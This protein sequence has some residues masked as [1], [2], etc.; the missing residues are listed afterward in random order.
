MTQARTYENRFGGL[1]FAK[2]QFKINHEANKYFA[3]VSARV[4]RFMFVLFFFDYFR[5]VVGKVAHCRV[6]RK[7][8]RNVFFLSQWKLYFPRFP[9][10][11]FT[12]EVFFVS[13]ALRVA[14]GNII[15][16]LLFCSNWKFMRFKI[17]TNSSL[18][19]LRLKERFLNLFT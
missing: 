9:V 3:S 10:V 5:S 4:A 19:K 15:I 8:L 2:V 1:K 6:K 12:C 11:Y 18:M 13:A 16:S 7:T 17:L 14:L